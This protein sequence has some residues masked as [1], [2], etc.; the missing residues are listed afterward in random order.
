MNVGK[1]WTLI[2]ALVLA[3]GAASAADQALTPYAAAYSLEYKGKDLGTAEFKLT[4]DQGR[5]VYEFYNRAQAK[6]FLKLARPNPVV[7]RSQFRVEG[8]RLVP[9]QYW[10]EDGSR[11]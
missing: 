10:Y 3:A 11:K 6:G 4:Y 7:D 5:G 8:N 9:L 1:Q 2:G